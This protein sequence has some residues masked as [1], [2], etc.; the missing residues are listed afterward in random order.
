V[1]FGQGLGSEN[2]EMELTSAVRTQKR[3]M[4]RRNIELTVEYQKMIER[5]FK[6]TAID[7]S[8][9]RIKAKKFRI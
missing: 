4:S 1:I 9:K 3:M 5:V 2:V 8:D 7:R 6:R